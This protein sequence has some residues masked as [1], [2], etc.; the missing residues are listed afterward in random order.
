MRSVKSHKARSRLRG[1]VHDFASVERAPKTIALRAY[2]IGSDQCEIG[3]ITV[4]AYAPVLAA[5]RELVKAGYDPSTPLEVYR[6]YTLALRVRSIGAGASLTVEDDKIGRPR[7]AK[8]RVRITGAA[9]PMRN[10][11]GGGR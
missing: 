5:C 4:T 7:F 2:L 11:D 8:F 10:R 1:A 6:G 3:A 9:T